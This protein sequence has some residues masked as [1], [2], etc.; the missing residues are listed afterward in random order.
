MRAVET[1]TA[2]AMAA[3]AAAT[4][5]VA[6]A[7]AAVE[8]A[9][10]AASAAPATTAGE[11]S[12][13]TKSSRSSA[14]AKTAEVAEVAAAVTVSP[15]TAEV[16]PAATAAVGTAT[17]TTLAMATSAAAT[18]EVATATEAAVETAASAVEQTVPKENV[19]KWVQQGDKSTAKSNGLLS[20]GLSVL[21]Q[22]ESAAG[23][24]STASP[25]DTVPGIVPILAVGILMITCAVALYQAFYGG[26]PETAPP[27]NRLVLGRHSLQSQAA[28]S[29]A[30]SRQSLPARSSFLPASSLS[31]AK[32][33]LME[34]P[35][36]AYSNSNSN[37]TPSVGRP[38][39]IPVNQLTTN[40]LMNVPPKPVPSALTLGTPR[41]SDRL[42]PWMPQPG[43][44]QMSSVSLK[45]EACQSTTPVPV[46]FEATADVGLPPPLYAALV[47]PARESH[48]EIP[49]ND[50]LKVLQAG[51]GSCFVLGPLKQRFLQITSCGNAFDVCTAPP[52]N[53][54]VSSVSRPN[55][56]TGARRLDILSADGSV[57][58]HIIPRPPGSS[59]TFSVVARSIDGSR[60]HDQLIVNFKA[61]ELCFT[62]VAAVSG[63]PVASGA[64]SGKQRSG[65]SD[66]LE[67]R[68]Q[69]RADTALV[70][71]S[72]LGIM[73]LATSSE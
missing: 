41:P 20:Y 36:N 43:A 38:A 10:S 53:A 58:G 59:H 7:T 64:P 21:L 72:F 17:A 50:L 51:S 25:G 19:P 16:V 15:A 4:A 68:T 8:T 71:S 6:P 73:L 26:A 61:N 70:L 5:A 37:S 67:I 69:R 29:A 32:S 30:T 48:L 42:S 18:A 24:R 44:E 23:G 13:Q 65:C 3:S 33:D 28:I 46:P 54:L 9:A 47:L 1:S 31:Y 66:N 56:E 14:A 49:V 22:L 12:S 55:D 57:Y 40:T 11:A 52:S 63:Q 27:S 34:D 60:A 2:S 45:G 35:Y 39:L 62:A